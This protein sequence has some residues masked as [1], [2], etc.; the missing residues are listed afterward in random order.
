MTIK[1]VLA[2]DH[3][4]VRAGLHLLIESQPDLSVIG[5]VANGRDAVRAVVQLRPDVAVIDIAMPDLNGIE[6][7]RQIH[8]EWPTTQIIIL[9]MYA[10]REHIYH[11]LKAGARGYV[12][13]EAAGDELIEAIR[14]VATGQRHLSR[15]IADDLV[16]DYLAQ[17][18]LG[19]KL[20]PLEQLSARE[21]EVL[22]L[23]AEGKSSAEI[24]DLLFLSPKTVSTYR[25][26]L[27]QKLMLPD[28]PS[29]IR[30]AI[31]AGI[32]AVE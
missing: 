26:R 21:R 19:E 29:L 5:Q 4:V 16:D 13:K 6:A 1:I 2:D 23:V 31:Q 12:L 20:S 9:S 24:A 11:A 17:P 7:A 18:A 30:F 25:S 14:T 8:K 15:K 10:T 22:Q 3:G 27:M 32:I 28:L